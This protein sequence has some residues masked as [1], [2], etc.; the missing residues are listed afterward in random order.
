[1][2]HQV[3]NADEFLKFFEDKTN[4]KDVTLHFE[5]KDNVPMP[6]LTITAKHKD[7]V[8]DF[9]T[10]NAVEIKLIIND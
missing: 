4:I 5:D 8:F 9:I 10:K 2:N 6:F 7:L 1:M 3:W